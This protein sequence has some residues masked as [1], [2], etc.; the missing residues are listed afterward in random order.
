MSRTL[1]LGSSDDNK[2]VHV[3]CFENTVWNTDSSNGA[4]KKREP[5][6]H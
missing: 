5:K 1:M 3:G 6:F 2:V 4:K